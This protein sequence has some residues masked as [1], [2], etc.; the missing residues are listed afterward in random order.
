MKLYYKKADGSWI[1]QYEIE[2][3]FY[4]STG[5]HRF[6]NEKKFLRWLY[7]LL[8]KIIICAKRSDDPE[9]VIELLKSKQKYSAIT[10]YKTINHCTLKEAR[11]AIDVIE[12]MTK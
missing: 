1:T 10:V 8:G 4:L 12:R 5:I 2:T 3:A 9:L 7:P 6:S 11:D